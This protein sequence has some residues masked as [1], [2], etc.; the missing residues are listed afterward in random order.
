MIGCKMGSSFN[1]VYITSITSPME[2][3][4]HG[5]KNDMVT[6]TAMFFARK[7]Y[8]EVKFLEQP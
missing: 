2:T 1:G 4:K 6:N 5:W 8:R 3:F 7:V